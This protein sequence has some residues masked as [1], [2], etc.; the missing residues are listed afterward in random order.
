MYS[1]YSS[2][3]KGFARFDTDVHAEKFLRN[4]EVVTAVPFLVSVLLA[5]S[6]LIR[7]WKC[8]LR[9]KALMNYEIS[10]NGEKMSEVSNGDRS[11]QLIHWNKRRVFNLCDSALQ[12][13]DRFCIIFIQQTPSDNLFA[14]RG[15]FHWKL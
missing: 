3:S 8:F 1:M 7:F 4:R 5:V 15:G 6:C 12:Q 10:R 11:S 13:C 2:R 14:L 9:K